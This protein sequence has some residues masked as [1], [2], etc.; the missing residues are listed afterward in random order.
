MNQLFP[1]QTTRRFSFWL[2]A[3]AAAGL[4]VLV[5]GCGSTSGYNQADKTGE[6]IN[7]LRNDI[8]N[9]KS[10]V[11]E[12][13]KALG[14]VEASASTDPRKPF[15][16][17]ARSVDKVDA[18]GKTAEKDANEMRERGAA[19]F[20]QWETQLSQVKSEDIR[21]LAQKR[22]ARLQEAF[23]SIK[24]AAQD[25]KTA[26]PVFLSDLKDLRTVLSTDLTIQG[27]D[28]AKSPIK[29][30]KKSGAVLQKDLDDLVAELNT[31]VAA[32]TAAKAPPPPAK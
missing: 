10:S 13:L 9:I 22:K 19:Y 24:T 25:A 30:A 3:I 26:F 15:D 1:M 29:K 7:T 11:D 18:A 28:S 21:E 16:V 17:F 8:V 5:A 14:A 31:V 2:S 6:A 23:D 32:I 4:A 12:S 27:I 20:Q